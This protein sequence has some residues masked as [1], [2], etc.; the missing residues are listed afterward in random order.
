VAVPKRKT[1]PSKRDMRRANHD[2]VTPV[3]V[4][5]C[6]NCGEPRLPHRACSACGH[7]DGRKVRAVK[8]T[9]GAT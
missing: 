3:Q 5:S 4:I 9:P 6:E 1:T 7:Y 2:K 8:G